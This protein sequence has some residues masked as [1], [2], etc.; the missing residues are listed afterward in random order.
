LSVV[1]LYLFG[2]PRIIL[3]DQLVQ[4]SLRKSISLFSYLSVTKQPHTRDA[5]AALFWPNDEQSKALGNL[6][7]SLHRITST[8]SEDLITASR[9]MIELNKKADVWLD[10]DTFQ[11]FID[12][13]SKPGKFI[14]AAEVS[15]VS[16]LEQAVKLYTG[17]FMAG[18]SLPDAP[19]FD[20]WQ[21]FQSENLKKSLQGS[22]DLLIDLKISEAKWDEG[23]SYARRR[24]TIDPYDE[25]SHRRLMELYARNNQTRAALRQYEECRR[26]LKLELGL[27][28]GRETTALYN[29]IRTRH[30]PSNEEANHSLVS[31]SLVYQKQ[32]VSENGITSSP[33]LTLPGPTHNLPAHAHPFI[34]RRKELEE[35][36]NLIVNST[37]HRLI[38]I[39][40]LGGIGKTRLALEVGSQVLRAFPDG[41][42]VVPGS[43]LRLSDE[44]VQAIADQIGLSFYEG[45]PAQK[46]L[47]DF[48]S[49]KQILLILDSFEHL[50]QESEIIGQIISQAQA[51]KILVTTRERLKFSAETVY[52]LGE[53]KYPE[54]EFHGDIYE[55]EAIKLFVQTALLVSPHLEFKEK[56]LQTA[57]RICRAVQGMPLAV[58][59]SA[60]WL[61]T[62]SLD[63]IANEIEL[64]L[65]FLES[66][67][68]DMPDRQKSIRAAIEYSWK[69]LSGEDQKSFIS[70]S[71]FVGGF[72][73]RAA[74]DVSG[75]SLRTLRTL[76]D[77]SLIV[78][79]QD[80]RYEIHKLLRQ[81]GEEH[82][83]A[84]GMATEIRVAHSRN[85]LLFLCQQ[86]PNIKG[87]RQATALK[88]IDLEFNNIRT[89]WE[90]SVHQGEI[91]I[92]D[93]ALEGLYLYCDLRGRQKEGA[94]L[95]SSARDKLAPIKSETPSL[96]YGRILT[97]L[98]MLRSR[99]LRSCPQI[100]KEIDEGLV[101]VS[102]YNQSPELAFGLLARGHFYSDTMQ[103]IPSALE[104]FENSLKLFREIE[105]DYYAARAL[106]M[107]GFCNA[108]LRG[109]E[110]L[111]YYLIE[112]LEL[113]RGLGIQSDLAMLLISL[114][115]CEFFLGD[116]PSAKR[117]GEQAS[118]LA[119]D[120]GP[121][122]TL[123]QT[124]IFL[125]L[126]YLV[127]GNL[128][129]ASSY[130]D[131]GNALAKKV[132]FPTP[133]VY[134]QTITGL[135]HSLQGQLEV[136]R[137]LIEK[138]LSSAIDPLAAA[139][140]HWAAA[141][142][143]SSKGNFD[144]AKQDI[145]VV[146]SLHASLRIPGII[147]LCLPVVS[148][149]L[150]QEK[151]EEQAILVQSIIQST[152]GMFGWLENWKLWQELHAR[153][154]KHRELMP[155]GEAIESAL[156]KDLD[157]LLEMISLTN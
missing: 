95:L 119:T 29:L 149:L 15:C 112:S 137:K 92:I 54:T 138:S 150:D 134:A 85:Y 121:G 88:E 97:Y 42:F 65:D 3:N 59:L 19:A 52:V 86:I 100:G 10:V 51:I 41:V 7:R 147:K 70:L 84:T 25:S 23:I 64:S 132:N 90:W 129:K 135:L 81:F 57:V 2:A 123:A 16:R 28:P 1:K 154:E 13:C 72:T 152:P 128:E 11:T 46:Q 94:E 83:H 89:A 110:V 32:K 79:N 96:V 116:F 106:H 48:L 12:A 108:F 102:S 75:A 117:Y 71:I 80:G 109:Q 82:L 50:I 49:E 55:Y 120:I 140:S 39:I 4:V 21:F 58:V 107:I 22:L 155:V 26:V 35:L 103:E 99:F 62:L 146:I 68:Q 8:L 113:T 31:N 148:L 9:H 27:E 61:T 118:M 156:Y 73:S 143:N 14:E 139:L 111:K 151:Q 105:D 24:I 30:L 47:L 17:D 122:P 114:S 5:L 130:L 6:R 63:E 43:T 66:Q 136:G 133:L 40:G 101:V 20:E 34:G 131:I 45:L 53:M 67:N 74:Q 36:K 56:D 98:G 91:H 126:I 33:R 37:N 144:A 115:M 153:I 142:A 78:H 125:S 44:L 60:G 77:K 69:R 104:N 145:Q 18:F 87:P 93:Q 124:H 76:V 157:D 38:T 141:V 127:E